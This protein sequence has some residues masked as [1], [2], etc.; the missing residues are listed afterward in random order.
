MKSLS[1]TLSETSKL[2]PYIGSFSKNT[3]GLSSLI[4]AL[5]NPLASSAFHG[6]TTFSPGQCAYQAA[7]H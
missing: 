6:A 1:R 4:A 5:S 7:K 3:T 2:Y